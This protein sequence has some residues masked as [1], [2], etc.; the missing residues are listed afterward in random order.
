MTPADLDKD[1]DEVRF[2]RLL[3]LLTE[4]CA[5]L[6][7]RLPAAIDAQWATAPVTRPR[8]DTAERAKGL[9]SDPTANIVLDERRQ[10]LRTQL[11]TSYALLRR[12]AVTVR[13]V[14]RGL[15][16]SFAA[17]EGEDTGDE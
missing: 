16:M 13:G 3:D 1:P 4:E 6:A 5:Q 14:R 8:E 12:A 2:A 11:V 9:K 10:H 17:W 7:A 15:E